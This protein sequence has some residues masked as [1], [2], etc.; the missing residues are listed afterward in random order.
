MD[1]RYLGQYAR[2]GI[3]VVVI[4][5]MFGVGT[6]YL[7]NIMHTQTIENSRII[8]ASFC[9]AMTFFL[10]SITPFGLGGSSNPTMIASRLFPNYNGNAFVFRKALWGIS[11]FILCLAFFVIG[12]GALVW[13]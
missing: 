2:R 8:L 7:W 13:E 12:Y 1:Y 6:G 5:F 4:V 11:M 10:N 3:W 9:L